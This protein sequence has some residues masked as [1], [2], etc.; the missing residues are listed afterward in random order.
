MSPMFEQELSKFVQSV[1]ALKNKD[2]AELESPAMQVLQALFEE[3]EEILSSITSKIQEP[4]N[5]IA[6]ARMAKA[7]PDSPYYYHYNDQI[8]HYC[9]Q[10]NID[11]NRFLPRGWF[12]ITYVLSKGI[13][14]RIVF[15]IFFLKDQNKIVILP[16]LEH[17]EKIKYQSKRGFKPKDKEHEIESDFVANG[18]D[19]DVKPFIVAADIDTIRFE[20][21]NLKSFYTQKVSLSLQKISEIIHQL[22][23]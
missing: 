21:E 18:I 9:K 13:K 23:N 14:F 4:L 2:W 10:L 17:L 12:K 16:F 5:E 1:T 19:F 3:S 11:V 8:H 20:A 6:V 7:F 15:C 22:I